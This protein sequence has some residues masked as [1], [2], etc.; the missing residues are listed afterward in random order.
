MHIGCQALPAAVHPPAAAHAPSLV[1]CTGC[2]A[3]GWLAR[4]EGKTVAIA[5]HLRQVLAQYKQARS[6]KQTRD[7]TAVLES[8][9]TLTTPA[10]PSAYPPNN[11]PCYGAYPVAYGSYG[12][13]AAYGCGTYPPQQKR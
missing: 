4:R 11:T 1:T 9:S 2:E 12:S 13:Y 10:T 5:S 7:A 6:L 8:T 3:R